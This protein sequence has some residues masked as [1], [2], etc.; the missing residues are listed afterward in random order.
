VDSIS[1]YP[2]MKLSSLI[3]HSNYIWRRD[4]IYEVTFTL[5]FLT[6]Y[7]YSRMWGSQS[8][9]YEAFFLV[10]YNVL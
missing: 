1:S 2:K 3:G 6:I 9:V 5:F 7:V 10:V 4:K 8:E